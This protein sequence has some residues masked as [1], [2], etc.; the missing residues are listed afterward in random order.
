MRPL[1]M[2]LPLL[3]RM[4]ETEA[5][6][7][8]NTLTPTYNPVT[9]DAGNNV[10]LT[11]TVGGN[12]SCSDAVDSKLLFIT[13][14]PT[15]NAGADL[16]TCE[17]S[18]FTV[19]DAAVA[20]DASVTWTHDGNGS[21]TAGTET[22]VNP[23][24]VP[25]PTD[26]GNNVTLT[27]TV[28]GNGSC[29]D[30]VDSKLLFITDAPTANA[31]ADLETANAGADLETCEDSPFTVTDAAVANDASVTWTHDGNG[32]FTAGTETTVNPEYV[33]DPTDAGNNVT[34]TLTVGGNGSCSDAVDSKLL[35]I[36]DAPTA[37]A[38]ADLETCE[39]S[40][41]TVT[42]AAVANDASVTWTHDGNGT[43]DDINT[44]TPT[45]NPV[46]ADAGNNVILTLTV[47]GNG[48][49]VNAVDTKSL[50]IGELPT[51]SIV[52]TASE[53][54]EADPFT[55][56]G[57]IGG[58][59]TSGLWRIKAGQGT[60]EENSG[61]LSSTTETTGEWKASFT[62]DGSFFGDVI[63]EFVSST[64]NSCPDEIK[65]YT[66]TITDLPEVIDQSYEFCEDTQG[67]G[68]SLQDLT[69]YNTDITNQNLSD[70]TIIW[71][72][73]EALSDPVND[74]ENVVAVN[75]DDFYAKVQFNA[76]NCF[77]VA[78]V[79]FT[80]DP[81]ITATAGSDEEI[82]NGEDFDLSTS[83]T[84]PTQ[85]NAE[86]L[87][88]TTNGDGSFDDDTKLRP[89]YTPGTNDFNNSPITLTLTA[90]NSASC[91]DVIDV[92][93]LTIKPVPVIN[94]VTDIDK[95]PNE[96]EPSIAFSADIAG[97]TFTWT[98]TN[99][100][101]L[102]LGAGS[103]TGDFPSF[104]T[105]PNNTGNTI[106]SEVTIDYLLNGC[107][108]ISETFNIN[109]LPT[110]VIDDVANI[111]VCPGEEVDII[112][113]ANTTGETFNWTNDDNS[114]GTT[115]ASSG[116][117][118]IN[119]TA[120]ENFT[121]TTQTSEF[122]Y[123]ATLDGCIS[124]EKTFTVNLLPE[125]V[126]TSVDDFEVC[127]FDNITT[128]FQSNVSGSLFSW[129]ND[130]TATGIPA[131]GNGNINVTAT[132][133]ITSAQIVSNITVTASRN[134]CIS[135]IETFTVT[136]KPKPVINDQA[137]IEICP[138]DEIASI[139]LIDDSG[140]NSTI[141][142][143]ATNASAI[144][145][146]A[147]SGTGNIPAFTAGNN[148]STSTITSNITVTSIWNGCVSDQESF[149]I[150]LKPTPIMN[151]VPNTELCAGEVYSVSFSNSLASGTTYN[152][153]N[154]NT[155]IG[156]AASGSGNIIFTTSSNT[157]GSS[158]IANITVTPINNS[159]EGP[160]EEFT[161]TLNPTPVLTTLPNVEYCSDESAIIPISTDLT[162]VNFSI[163]V[164]DNSL[165]SSDPV[166]NGENIEFTTT[167][168]TSGSDL[169][170][171]ITVTAEKNGCESNESFTVT[172]K[173]R[174]IINS[175]A[176][177]AP[178]CSG[179]IVS[180]RTFTHDSG[181]GDF[182]W[183]ILNSDLI[184][185]GTSTSGNGSFPGFELAENIS[186]D[187][188]EGYVKYF[189]ES[190]GCLSLADSFKITLKPSPVILNVDT[191]FCEGEFVNIEFFDNVNDN[192]IYE[193]QIDNLT[194][195]INNSDGTTNQFITPAGFT[196]VNPSDTEDN[197]ANIT[198]FSTIDGCAGPVKTIEVRV[199][200]N[201]T[202]SNNILEFTT[203]SNETF[204]FIPESSISSTDFEWNFISGDTTV[205][206]GVELSGTG[207]INLDLINT[208]GT[209]QDLVYEI[210]PLN[211]NC[212]GTSEEL[213]ITVTP[214]IKFE[215][216]ENEYFVCSGQ[217]FELPITLANDLHLN[218]IEYDWT[219]SENESGANDSTATIVGG[220]LTN[221]VSG[222]RDTVIYTIT[223]KLL[224]GTCSGNTKVIS[225]IINPNAIVEILDVNDICEGDNI[226]LE[227]QLLNGAG[228]GQW[229]GGN[230]IF[231]SITSPITT[232]IPDENEFG[233][234]ITLRFTAN[235]P[236]GSGP[237]TTSYDEV[238]FTINFLPNVAITG[239]PFPNN[240]YCIRNGIQELNGSPAGGIFSGRGI[241]EED[242]K[243]FFNPEVATVGGPYTINY[244][245]TN[246]N[247]CINS[248]ETTVQV[249]NGPN[250]D[251]DIDTD[252]S[253]GFFCSNA[254][255][256]L[257]PASAG[258]TFSGGGIVITGGIT[259]FDAA[260]PEVAGLDSVE[261][262]YTI[263]ED[264]TSCTA[265]TTK[266]IK[267]IPA[268]EIEIVYQNVCEI[269]NAVQIFIEPGYNHS[270]D[271]LIS[272]QLEYEN[273][274]NRIYEAGQIEQF[275]SPGVKTITVIGTSALGCVF[276]TTTNINVGNIQKT[277]FSVS[278]LK[279]SSSGQDPTQ[280]TNESMLNVLNG[281]PSINSIISF[282]WD[283]GVEGIETDTSTLENPS[284]NYEN[285]GAYNVR[286]IIESSLGCSDTII[287]KIDIVPAIDSYPYLET[288]NESSGGWYTET[289]DTTQSSWIH[290][291]PNGAF[292]GINDNPS[293]QKIWKTAKNGVSGY[294]EFENS[295][296]FGPSFDLTNLDKP[297]IAFDMWLDVE[298][299]NR[300]G[301]IIEFSTDG[302]NW[303][304]LGEINDELNWY[305]T[306]N[307]FPIGGEFSNSEAYA[308]SFIGDQRQWI[309]TAHTINESLISD[310][311][312]VI[313]RINFRTH[314][315][316]GSPTGMAIDNFYVGERQKLVLLESFTNLNSTNYNNNRTNVESLM[317]G[318]VGKDLLPLNFHISIPTPDSI[319]LRNSVE[320][321][322]RASIYDIESSPQLIIDGELFE[323][324]LFESSG[325]LDGEFQRIITRRSLLEPSNL[326]E[327]S[328][329]NNADTNTIRFNATMT[330][331]TDPNT[332]LIAHYFI[333]EKSTNNPELKN[334]VRKILPNINGIDL[335]DISE[336]T[337]NTY[338]WEVNSIYSSDD[339]AIVS[340]VQ[341][342]ITNRI[343]EIDIVDIEESKKS[344]IILN[345]KEGFES[346]GMDLYPNPS[347]GNINIR[348]SKA[349][350]SEI[351]IM[352]LD[353]NGKII[354]TTKIASNT[355]ETELD[356]NG[357]AS[358]VYHIISKNSNGDLNRQKI[359]LID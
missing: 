52:T 166:L 266:T 171:N 285:A 201:P 26:A 219:V 270:Q 124:I 74:E 195:G 248:T 160:E 82:C 161:L 359:V 123:S 59:S 251:F 286:L 315:I 112:F 280:F 260:S 346:I 181:T 73:D 293:P 109:V 156:L 284:F 303:K 1:Q 137:N 142:W 288:F 12:G 198:V 116:S 237:C 344:K 188:I 356:L 6:D 335:N 223:P 298:N 309:R 229:S 252:D 304:I 332:N 153:V 218:D 300:A 261:I 345:I 336:T 150:Q 340:I 238:T 143:T 220:N 253:E 232:Y 207:E 202:L 56:T 122:T 163:N 243:Y 187:K 157:T 275:N 278:N 81:Q 339:L 179:D 165:F 15:A 22:T 152:W 341:D 351:D 131:S 119:F 55:L 104:T 273:S 347:R 115:L 355:V 239:N 217:D 263:F 235:D 175:E 155:N 174:A 102:G 200:P 324:N 44:L 228:S 154:D 296:L 177:E 199:L 254:F 118:D 212:I 172:L 88:W 352:I 29:S 93:E 227:A 196:A 319:N 226:T 326:I 203:C 185:D 282:N 31:G 76:T 173:N 145:L 183:E 136:L 70:V 301:A 51:S 106:T 58:G 189:S 120:A 43:L 96:S 34:L 98:A 89:I 45:Y 249:T 111:N 37:N 331:N 213:T 159:C 139:G 292:E 256:E 194:I 62:P 211:N 337:T 10:T 178:L 329:D 276:E 107:S 18:P 333:V 132:E 289:S 262:T 113:S 117:G 271:S 264:E 186:G 327:V 110:P 338:E 126:L 222:Q 146:P 349:L 63:F 197:V 310:L 168:N 305:N 53:V 72:N 140:G 78:K 322:A 148:N 182:S 100:E 259:Y 167:I 277:D 25:D 61:T 297:M 250:S 2:M 84:I 75:G 28:S 129:T 204:T 21:F 231:T 40:P 133:N 321:D 208:S 114:I 35:F 169:T 354:K 325:A 190:N 49:C 209:N 191:A 32:S 90:S 138:G 91:P 294:S 128:N 318:A 311:S 125:P 343:F 283:F 210:T 16:E 279:T 4:T 86:T 9:A 274:P 41:F 50:F 225:V 162:G 313:F 246:S 269:D 320:L 323:G 87:L 233:E 214:E 65:E 255:L 27:L 7:D 134:G 234:N 268:P 67:D 205:V 141:S 306:R 240:L 184:G 302:V 5:L 135:E 281:D 77:D 308:W 71:Y 215:N 312:S 144:G 291:F 149:Q 85:S 193:W 36:T 94:S 272:Y 30:A 176:D 42:D 19:T 290:D 17:D 105:E 244:E 287:K 230:G 342:R 20:N 13:D 8:I 130:N 64:S 180:S 46:T 147:S 33:P 316:D 317:D 69:V 97:G 242:G 48:S 92:M 127:S 357:I 170:S 241:F 358:G 79:D 121:G 334:I 257:D 328:I 348:F 192:A 39:D 350:N 38:G 101:Q 330:P 47:S 80:I 224:D 247:G 216:L 24:Y 206:N 299:Q 11:L 245:F 221:S 236:D 295:Y 151:S 307:T 66:L 57:T 23:E 60:D 103:G 353:S 83:S 164:S 54:C 314:S 95:C 108:S 99:F 265:F 14:A 267:R 258:G 68:E 3:G 158:I